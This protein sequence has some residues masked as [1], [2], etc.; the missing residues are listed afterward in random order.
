MEKQGTNAAP[1]GQRV[2]PKIPGRIESLTGI[3]PL[4]PSPGQVILQGV[5]RKIYFIVFPAIPG[6]VKQARSQN[7]LK[8]SALVAKPDQLTAQVFI[9]GAPVG[10]G[11]ALPEGPTLPG[12][13]FPSLRVVAHSAVQLRKIIGFEHSKRLG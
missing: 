2:M 13:F 8:I 4:F 6:F 10:Q 12:D 1:R 9:W 11:K 3:A 7:R 5:A